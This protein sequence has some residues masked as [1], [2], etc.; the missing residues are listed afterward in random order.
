[1]ITLRR[2]GWLIPLLLLSTACSRQETA[3]AT[4]SAADSPAAATAPFVDETTADYFDLDLSPFAVRE[5][6]PS[7]ASIN[8][9]GRPLHLDPWTLTALLLQTESHSTN[10]DDEAR[11]QL[12]SLLRAFDPSDLER[13]PPELLKTRAL[14][15]IRP[16]IGDGAERPARYNAASASLSRVVRTGTWQC[17]TGTQLFFLSALRLPADAFRRHHFVLIYER[18]H[19]LPGYLR[20]INGT[21]FLYGIEMTVLGAGHKPY[22]P[23]PRLAERGFDLRIVS[24][25]EALTLQAVGPYLT[26]S[27][28]LATHL[29]RRTAERYDI[30]LADL[31][32]NIRASEQRTQRTT[33]GSTAA[34]ADTNIRQP[35]LA[36]PWAFGRAEVPEGDRPMLTAERLNPRFVTYS[37]T[38]VLGMLPADATRDD[39]LNPHATTT[40]S[41]GD[42][43]PAVG[44]ESD[45]GDLGL[46]Y[47]WHPDYPGNN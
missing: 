37:F 44:E 16:Q 12:E 40:D 33:T 18:G 9:D 34:G 32:R 3:T 15:F 28:T 24:A 7:F 6:P 46:V 5:W 36:S 14:E 39:P 19:V 29:L 41:E 25:P 38:E 23:T 42:S 17:H 43:E 2:W 26:N 1:M 11:L 30:P 8:L 27:A 35:A 45:E 20:Q 4:T 13:A 47:P 10:R 31:E 22:G 21:W